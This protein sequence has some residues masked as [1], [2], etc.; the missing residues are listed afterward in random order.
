MQSWGKHATRTAGAPSSLQ[1][2]LAEGG[3]GS[4]S[5]PAFRVAPIVLAPPASLPS[6]EVLQDADESNG[7]HDGPSRAGRFVDSAKLSPTGHCGQ[8]SDHCRSA[9]SLFRLRYSP[10]R[11]IVYFRFPGRWAATA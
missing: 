2:P 4:R 6:E 11:T 10:A 5:V 1:A 8:R 3:W 7:L 9:R